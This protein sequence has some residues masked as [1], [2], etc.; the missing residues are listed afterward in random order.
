V[1]LDI[2]NVYFSPK[3]AMIGALVYPPGMSLQGELSIFGQKLL[4]VRGAIEIEKL[5][6]QFHASIAA[7]DLL[8]L[9]TLQGKEGNNITVR[10]NP[11][12]YFAPLKTA[13]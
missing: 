9:I 1:Q 7:I 13:G 4:Q 6:A 3:G 2:L 11:H 10:S 5:K 12:S 8:G